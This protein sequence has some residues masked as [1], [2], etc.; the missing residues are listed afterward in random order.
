MAIKRFL[1]EGRSPRTQPIG[2]IFKG[3]QKTGNKPG[4]N[5]DYFR[6]EPGKSNVEKQARLTEIWEQYYGTQPTQV[7]VF[8]KHN[9]VENLIDD[10]FMEF[11]TGGLLKTRCDG[12]NIVEWR[13]ER[14]KF[15]PDSPKPCRAP[16]SPK[17]CE[18]CRASALIKFGMPE[19]RYHGFSG[20]IEIST[21]SINDI[22]YLKTQL[23]EI[24]AELAMVST[25][26]AYAPL[27]LSRSPRTITKTT[28]Q[29]QF[30]GEENL[31]HLSIDPQ[32]QRKLDRAIAAQKYHQIGASYESSEKAAALIVGG[33]D[34]IEV[35]VLIS[36]PEQE[37][38]WADFSDACDRC[39]TEEKLGLLT[40]W[41]VKHPEAKKHHDN[42]D[43]IAS[44][45]SAVAKRI[46]PL[47]EP[48]F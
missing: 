38:F 35:E 31:L 12:E 37:K 33:V 27:I 36:T 39:D 8:F 26:I 19:F 41:A 16:N 3:A 28:P 34:P 5:L 6:F 22:V 14:G 42:D 25:P 20:N 2:K 9:D 32:F 47:E 24:A 10:W 17:G 30:R 48:E 29:K 15:Y 43:A 13:D 40:A 23:E 45:L 46:K 1:K 21:T 18:K 7:N 11:G 4:S 44:A